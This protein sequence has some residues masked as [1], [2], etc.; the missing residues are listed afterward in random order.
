MAREPDIDIEVDDRLNGILIITCPEC[1]HR[2]RKPLRTLSPGTE[3]R[4]SCGFTVSISGD[5]LRAVQRSL[6]DLKG[7]L[8]AFGK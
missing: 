6:D 7:T 1:G 8:Q 5:D 2:Q 3:L 4:C